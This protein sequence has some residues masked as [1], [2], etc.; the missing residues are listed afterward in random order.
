MLS[1]QADMSEMK[2]LD[3]FYCHQSIGGDMLIPFRLHCLADNL[4]T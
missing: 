4:D 1:S 3:Y 2:Y